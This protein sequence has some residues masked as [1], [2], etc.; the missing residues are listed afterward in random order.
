VLVLF[1]LFQMALVLF[2]LLFFFQNAHSVFSLE[3]FLFQLELPVLLNLLGH[4]RRLLQLPCLRLGLPLRLRGLLPAPLLKLFQLDPRILLLPFKLHSL[5]DQQLLLLL[6]RLCKQQFFL[7]AFVLCH[8]LLLLPLLLQ[9][10]SAFT[11]S[12]FHH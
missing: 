2:A 12:L 3:S 7:T 1:Q 8:G 9:Q 4:P 11:V 5:L 10:L 6:L